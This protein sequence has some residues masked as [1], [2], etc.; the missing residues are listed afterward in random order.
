MK[1][2]T[3]NFLKFTGILLFS[4]I[5]FSSCEK[6]KDNLSKEIEI[7]PEAIQ[8]NASRYIAS[9]PQAKGIENRIEANIKYYF[10]PLDTKINYYLEKAGFTYKNVQELNF[11][12]AEITLIS[13]TSFNVKTIV[14]TKLYLMSKSEFDAWDESEEKAPTPTATA[15]SANGKTLTFK[16]NKKD[17]MQYVKTKPELYLFIT[18]PEQPIVKSVIETK[19]PVKLKLQL[20]FKAK[21]GPLS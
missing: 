11:T 21:V 10:S 8:F 15:V 12:S 2:K 5:L 18:G 19:T 7:T 17:F 20:K 13:P 16:I 6:A 9:R 3:K 14:G 4:L 1:T